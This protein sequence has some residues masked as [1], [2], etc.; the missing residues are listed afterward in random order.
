MHSLLRRAP[1]G[2]VAALT[3]AAAGIARAGDTT[4]SRAAA[5]RFAKGDKMRFALTWDVGESTAIAGMAIDRGSK[6]TLGL[7][8]VVDDVDA[9]GT[10]KM[11]S[12]IESI[13]LASKSQTPMGMIDVT[14]DS[15]KH[16]E[17]K[18]KE[19]KVLGRAVGK[20]FHWKVAKDGSVSEV[21]GV[22]AV[23]D[24]I[25]Q[26]IQAR[27]MRGGGP[28][29]PGGGGNPFG[30]PGGGDMSGMMKS[31]AAMNAL[32]TMTDDSMQAS[33]DFHLRLFSS[34][35]K[36]G[37]WELTKSMTFGGV[38][39]SG[40]FRF[41]DKGPAD[42]GGQ[43]GQRIIGN[44][45]ELKAKLAV[46]G[47]GGGGRMAGMMGK[48]KVKSSACTQSAV[49][50]KDAGRLLADEF[51]VDSLLEAP[52]PNMFGGPPGG[53]KA[54]G[55]DDDDDEDAPRAKKKDKGDKDGGGEKTK[56]KSKDKDEDEDAPA[57][58]Q[59]M[60]VKL[61]V[62]GRWE[63]LTGAAPP[64]PAIEEDK[65]EEEKKPAKGGDD[66]EDEDRPAKKRPA[67]KKDDEKKDDKKEEKKEKPL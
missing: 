12:T 10:A 13:A 5:Y 55:G 36:D 47:M 34:E 14:Y 28:R 7:A 44:A 9:S 37:A 43:K 51:T 18:T 57:P 56:E 65:D 31:G 6:V 40:K 4:D 39:I 45:A 63:A 61:K 8:T 46:D 50:S 1:L 52:M 33:L 32:V 3:I 67:D 27:M 42:Q 25:A 62:V 41:E 20:S 60:K 66:D 21:E 58:A 48:I 11:T 59:T 2:A 22:N 53:R 23:R 35:T 16:A 19:L 26:K 49:Y 29:G 64:A 30:G 24:E 17:T 15:A 38:N 54:P